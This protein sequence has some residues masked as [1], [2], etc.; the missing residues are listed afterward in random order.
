MLC[1]LLSVLAMGATSVSTF[2]AEGNVPKDF[3]VDGVRVHVNAENN[4]DQTIKIGCDNLTNSPQIQART[5]YYDGMIDF[6]YGI[7]PL[8][9]SVDYTYLWAR[10]EVNQISLETYVNISRTHKQT[11]TGKSIQYSSGRIWD[12]T[13]K[14]AFKASG[15]GYN[16]YNNTANFGWNDR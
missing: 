5:S 15:Y 6:T 9:T 8:G 13:G 10:T 14:G 16:A 12:Y 2:A 7:Q 4:T 11:A 3:I 1:V